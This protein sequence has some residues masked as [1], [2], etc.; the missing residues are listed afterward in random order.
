M[1]DVVLD[2][3]V[4]VGWLDKSDV[5]NRRATELIERLKQDGHAALL[6]DVFVSEAVSVICR[7]ARER[8]PTRSTCSM[9][10]RSCDV[11]TTQARSRR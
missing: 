4:I 11:G 5:H 7:R 9:P 10:L 6:L 8:R 2:A 1:A 3:N